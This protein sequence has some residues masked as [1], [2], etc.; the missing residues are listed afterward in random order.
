MVFIMGS[1]ALVVDVGMVTVEKSRLQN[2]ADSAVMA[3]VMDLPSVGTARST[4]RSYAISNGIDSSD[5][6][7]TTPYD[8]DSRKIKVECKRT[9][10]YTFARVLGFIE[11]EVT[12]VAVAKNT[13][14][15]GDALPFLNMLEYS[16]GNEI[17]VWDKISSGDFMSINDYEMIN[18]KD[19]A[20]VYFKLDYMDGVELTKGTVATIKQEIG[21]IYD[22]TGSG[23]VY[24]VSLTQSVFDT[25]KVLLTNGILRNLTKMKNT[26]IV[27]PSQLILLEC[28]FDGY[29]IKNKTLELTVT[30][31]YDFYN[32]EFPPE[33]EPPDGGVSM[34]IRE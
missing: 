22:R 19:P 16:V 9:V 32:G 26:D 10:Q 7:V 33:Y 29:D 3:A 21:Y 20:T 14:W 24:L 30:A 28:D 23:K 8:G 1:A 12:A 4:A 11:T 25:Q 5:I 17:D 31:D 18:E 2:A 27:D 13:P 34:L 15:A 6:T